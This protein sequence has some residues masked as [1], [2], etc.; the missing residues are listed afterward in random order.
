MGM[1]EESIAEENIAVIFDGCIH[2]NLDDCFLILSR[3]VIYSCIFFKNYE[4]WYSRTLVAKPLAKTPV[5][6]RTRAQGKGLPRVE[7]S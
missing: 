5:D 2:L 6:P 1:L 7:K 3:P 4:G